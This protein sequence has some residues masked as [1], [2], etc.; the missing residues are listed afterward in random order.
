MRIITLTSDWGL[1]DHYLGAV[2]GTI[3]TLIPDARIIDITHNITPYDI[4]SASFVLKNAFLSF[5]EGTVHIVGINTEASLQNAH[6]VA[7]YKKHYFIGTDNGIF[8]L[9]F[10]QSADKIVEIDIHQDSDFF[11]FPTR[12]VFVKVAAHIFEKGEIDSLGNVKKSLNEKYF[13]SPVTVNN[14]IKGNVLYIDSYGNVITNISLDLFKSFTKGK[15]FSINF[16]GSNYEIQKISQSYNDVEQ[17]EKLAIFST[18]GLLEI[19][20]NQGQASSLLGLHPNDN[21]NVVIE[22]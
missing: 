1:R 18:T 7:L 20:L 19:A 3:L 13:I 21:V 16:R 6:I 4:I 11:T 9:I 5:P 22:E 10:E 17:G 2:K 8:S 14:V 12:D 15:H